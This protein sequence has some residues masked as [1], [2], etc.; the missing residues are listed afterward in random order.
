MTPQTPPRA[1]GEEV[2]ASERE[3]VE[4]KLRDYFPEFLRCRDGAVDAIVAALR[5]SRKA[6]IEAARVAIEAA[7]DII[8]EFHA[9]WGGDYLAKKW[10]L[11]E[12]VASFRD[13]KKPAALA[14]LSR[15]AG[16]E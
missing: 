1:E 3:I 6:D 14:A 9:Q 13:E 11:D 10:G 15:L 2:M 16:G 5:E 4:A 12:G 8:D 7:S